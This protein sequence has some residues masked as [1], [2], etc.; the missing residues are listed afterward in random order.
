MLNIF[1]TRFTQ[2]FQ[3]I[4]TFNKIIAVNNIITYFTIKLFKYFKFLLIINILYFRKFNNLHF[5][6][7]ICNFLNKIIYLLVNHH[8]H[9]TLIFVTYIQEVYIMIIIII[10]NNMY[11]ILLLLLVILFKLI[12]NLMIDYFMDL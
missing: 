2:M 10:I 3:T 12:I 1:I 4:F 7:L 8:Y 5:V 11:L 6:Y 9:K